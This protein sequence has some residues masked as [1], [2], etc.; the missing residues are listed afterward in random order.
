[1]KR[2]YRGQRACQRLPLYCKLYIWMLCYWDRIVNVSFILIILL[3]VL[4]ILMYITLIWLYS[5]CKDFQLYYSHCFIAHR[6][7]WMNYGCHYQDVMWLILC[8]REIVGWMGVFQSVRRLIGT[9]FFWISFHFFHFLSGLPAFFFCDL[10]LAV[11]MFLYVLGAAHVQKFY[12][13]HGRAE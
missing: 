2:Q 8:V 11:L 9:Y 6:G 10:I 3:N 5:L 7:Q 12:L 13:S 1:M 4:S